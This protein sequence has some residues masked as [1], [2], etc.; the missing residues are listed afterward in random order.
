[1]T[2]QV[3]VYGKLTDSNAELSSFSAVS[4]FLADDEY[5][6]TDISNVA[7]AGN[8]LAQHMNSALPAEYASVKIP[9]SRVA[10]IILEP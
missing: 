6:F 1:M 10:F 7:G 9:A 4:C 8:S 2:Y 3:H 5:T